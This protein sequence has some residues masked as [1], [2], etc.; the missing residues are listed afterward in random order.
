VELTACEAARFGFRHY[1]SSVGHAG[2]A[3]QEYGDGCYA[4]AAS[5]AIRSAQTAVPI[6]QAAT[7]ARSMADFGC[8]QGAWLSAWNEA[9]AEVRGVDG[10][11]VVCEKLLIPQHA[12]SGTD[13]AKPIDLGRRFDLVQS[14]E[15]AE[16]LPPASSWRLCALV[17]QATL[18]RYRRPAI[19]W[20][21]R[22]HVQM[23][24]CG[25]QT[26]AALCRIQ[27][28]WRL[29]PFCTERLTGRVQTAA[30]QCFRQ[31]QARWAPLATIYTTS[32]L[33]ATHWPA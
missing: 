27:V 19:L 29:A 26:E 6:V 13:L 18:V 9:G 22:Q 10:P 32:R 1:L 15:T 7:C 25:T 23:S 20:A 33:A 31:T 2:K 12:F 5:F 17:P 3:T 8:G 16:H 11:Y 4:F 28:L 14:L 30:A 21:L 24:Q